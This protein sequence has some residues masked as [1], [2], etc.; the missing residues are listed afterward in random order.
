MVALLGAH[1]IG[2]A[3]QQF[4]GF[5]GRWRPCG[6][7]NSLT[8]GLFKAITGLGKPNLEWI[9][10]RASQ[11]NGGDANLP[12]DHIQWTKKRSDPA[13]NGRSYSH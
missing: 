8:N 2:R 13:N 3:K 7:K 6:V 5:Q 4:S 9:Q 10:T 11:N 12:D 1:Q